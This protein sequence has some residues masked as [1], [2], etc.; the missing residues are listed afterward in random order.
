MVLAFLDF[1]TG[2]M[3]ESDAAI[4]LFEYFCWIVTGNSLLIDAIKMILWKRHFYAL[5]NFIPF[6]GL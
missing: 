4:V 5:Y 2:V 3:H 1:K 6:L